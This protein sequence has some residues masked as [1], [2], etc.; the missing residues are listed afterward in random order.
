MRKVPKSGWSA[1]TGDAPV[2]ARLGILPRVP[3]GPSR[4]R[5]EYSFWGFSRGSA[6]VQAKAAVNLTRPDQ[7]DLVARGR[8]GG[9]RVPGV[10]AVHPPPREASL[11]KRG[12]HWKGE[13]E[14][15]VVRIVGRYRS[16]DSVWRRDGWSIEDETSGRFARPD[17]CP[18]PRRALTLPSTYRIGGRRRI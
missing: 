8:P 12:P 14:G 18:P 16:R 5:R 17:S 11:R 6:T 4:T 13:G 3:S 7:G 2:V 15:T 9:Y 1:V 10:A